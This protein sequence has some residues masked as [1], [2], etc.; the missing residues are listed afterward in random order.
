MA[1]YILFYKFIKI[2]DGY[3]PCIVDCG[4][5]T[6]KNSN[7]VDHNKLIKRYF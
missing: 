5:S 2:S 6:L 4:Y 3:G 7:I 1:W